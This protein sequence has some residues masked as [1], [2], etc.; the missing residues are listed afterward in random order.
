MAINVNGKTLTSVKVGSTTVHKVNVITNPS[1][2]AYVTV[3]N[4]NT[5]TV[6]YTV[7]YYNG[8][9]FLTS[10]E[11]EKNH[12]ISFK[13]GYNVSGYVWQGWYTSSSLSNSDRFDS[14]TPITSNLDLY[15][16]YTAAQSGGS[17]IMLDEAKIRLIS[18]R[19]K[20]VVVVAQMITEE[21]Q[22]GELYFISFQEYYDLFQQD[23]PQSNEKTGE[24]VS[25]RYREDSAFYPGQEVDIGQ[26]LIDFIVFVMLRE[27]ESIY[28]DILMNAMKEIVQN[29]EL[30][31]IL[32]SLKEIVYNLFKNALEDHEFNVNVGELLSTDGEQDEGGNTIYYVNYTIAMNYLSNNS[33]TLNLRLEVINKIMEVLGIGSLDDFE[34]GSW[35]G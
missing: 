28:A 3:F 31:K 10:E 23:L 20:E 2:G 29:G 17:E 24:S 5:G 7:R 30:E 1:T 4:D 8:T 32:T 27:N 14:S 25:F 13:N 18:D 16:K 33:D 19:E 11:V 12:T 21:L 34:N 6:S 9:D 35:R 22:S 26:L 15:G